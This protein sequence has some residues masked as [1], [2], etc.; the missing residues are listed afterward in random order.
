MKIR[1]NHEPLR[2]IAIFDH[3]YGGGFFKFSFEDMKLVLLYAESFE[4]G[5]SK[6]L[7]CKE[8]GITKFIH[9]PDYVLEQAKDYFKAVLIKELSNVYI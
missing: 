3:I 1:V 5:K 4:D 7:Y 6:V 9:I 2:E 8:S